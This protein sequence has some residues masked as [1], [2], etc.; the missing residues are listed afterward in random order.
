M[1]KNPI[2]QVAQATLVFAWALASGHAFAQDAG[3]VEPASPNGPDVQAA[4]GAAPEAPATSVPDAPSADAQDAV[5]PPSSTETVASPAPA[6]AANETTSEDAAALEALLVDEQKAVEA[7][8]PGL[9]FYGFADAGLSRTYFHDMVSPPSNAAFSV[10][11]VNLYMAA[12]LTRGFSSLVEVRFSY[13]PNGTS[14]AGGGYTSTDAADGANLQRTEQWGGIIM[15][16][17]HV[18]YAYRS[19]LNLRLGQF[20]TPYG[21]WNVDHG[22]P[23]I[24]PTTKP[25]IVG[26]GLFPQRQTGLEV[27][28]SKLVGETTLGY[29][30]TVSNGRS[31]ILNADYDKNKALGGRLFLATDAVGSLKLGVSAYGGRATMQPYTAVDLSSGAVKL[32]TKSNDQYDELALAADVQWDVKGFHFQSEAVARQVKYLEPGRKVYTDPSGV[33]RGQVADNLSWGW[34]ALAG[35]RLPWLSLMPFVMLEQIENVTGATPNQFGVGKPGN[36]LAYAA[37]L[38]IRP[39][40]SLVLKGQVIWV[41]L[42]DVGKTDPQVTLIAGQVAWAF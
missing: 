27:F 41:N 2:S 35:Y 30:F 12:N 28:G 22:S 21:I 19:W 1:K 36:T 25:Y 6:A 18:D 39:V 20:L 40:P 3:G 16:R 4:I 10:G 32:L 23:T 29:H 24:I 37:G 15:Q 17:V 34:Y 11:N 31:D 38:N 26:E 13:M 7:D 33:T 5:A 14:A 9:T 8:G 42:P